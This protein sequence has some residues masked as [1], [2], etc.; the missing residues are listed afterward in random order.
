[1]ADTA[2]VL[3]THIRLTTTYN[4]S[5]GRRDASDLHRYLRAHIPV[6]SCTKP[7]PADRHT[8]DQETSVSLIKRNICITDSAVTMKL[9][10]DK[11]QG[12]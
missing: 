12:K 2:S 6:L 9:T 8:C 3:S 10:G 1:M 5:S 4:C 7:A 11:D